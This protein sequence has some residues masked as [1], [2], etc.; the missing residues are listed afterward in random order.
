MA[1]EWDAR[2]NHRWGGGIAWHNQTAG[3]ASVAPCVAAKAGLDLDAAV[4]ARWMAKERPDAV[5]VETLDA[6]LVDVALAS[7]PPGKR[8]KIVTMNWPNRFAEFG[9]DQR[10]ERIGAVAI[11]LLT[12]MIVRGEKGIPPLANHTMIDGCW[13]GLKL[14][15]NNQSNR[16]AIVAG[17]TV[18]CS[19]AS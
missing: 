6:S 2:V 13:E 8:P 9:I 15:S 4:L 5:I 3:E 14:P 19:R 16:K 10:P 12:A 11:E 18:P 7:L 17:K 1:S